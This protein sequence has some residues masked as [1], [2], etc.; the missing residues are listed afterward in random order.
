MLLLYYGAMV[1]HT[2][3][4]DHDS[5]ENAITLVALGGILIGFLGLFLRSKKVMALF[6]ATY[7]GLIIYIMVY[8]IVNIVSNPL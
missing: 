6:V 7:L 8:V 1:M 3:F 4:F 5:I 2:L